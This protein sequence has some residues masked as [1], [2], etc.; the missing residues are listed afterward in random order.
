M[1]FLEYREDG[2]LSVTADVT[3][4]D[5]IPPYAILSHTWRAEAEE[6]AFEDLASSGG[7]DKPG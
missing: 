1:R 4:E 3:N 5:A 2:E 6:L 7:K